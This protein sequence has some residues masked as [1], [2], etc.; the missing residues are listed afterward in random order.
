MGPGI[1]P[2]THLGFRSIP[3]PGGYGRAPPRRYAN[4]HHPG[5]NW[6]GSALRRAMSVL[7]GVPRV[8]IL[9]LGVAIIALVAEID[10]L[11]GPHASLALLYV[12]PIALVTWYVSAGW[13]FF[14]AAFA[15][16][17]DSA[18]AFRGL[19]S[20]A[21]AWL[22]G[23]T[24][25]ARMISFSV[26]A[27]IIWTLHRA[28]ENQRALANTDPVTGIGNTRAYRIAASR[29]I[30][31]C[32]RQRSPITAVY[33]DLDNFKA[34]NDRFGHARGD[35]LLRVVAATLTA[36]L[37]L[38]DHVARLG[39]DEF[40]LV[41]PDAGPSDAGPL[42]SKLHRLL[43][44]EME[45]Y[46]WPVTFSIG[47]ATFAKAPRSVDDL[48]ARADALQYRAKSSG[49]NRI[50]FDVDPAAEKVVPAE[51]PMPKAA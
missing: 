2:R 1:G 16:I 28:I 17:V 34:V 39:G 46:G 37:R 23:W 47:V 4:V 50:I 7:E 43:L 42:I 10:D 38:T 35:R 49:K 12:L 48:L 30:A 22:I 19:P 33:L 45:R 6:L 13:G 5:G 18:L 26:T 51:V 8:L 3:P 20:G 24:F 29:E 11:S 14:F 40:A 44:A 32:E 36:N 21:S 15:G 9:T 25:V 41:L 31:R 27:G